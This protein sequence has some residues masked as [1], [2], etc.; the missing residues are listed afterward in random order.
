MSDKDDITVDALKQL[1]SESG[2]SDS[3]A[4]MDETADEL[5]RRKRQREAKS[6]LRI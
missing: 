2:E 4:I 3:S 5:L 6:L 1:G